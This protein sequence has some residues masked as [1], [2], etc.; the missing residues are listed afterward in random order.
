MRASRL[1]VQQTVFRARAQPDHG[2]RFL[3]AHKQTID[4]INMEKRAARGA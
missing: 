2:S 4:F 3:N 1:C